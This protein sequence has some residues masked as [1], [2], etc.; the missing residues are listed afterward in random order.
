MGCSGNPALAT[1]T[2]VAIGL[3]IFLAA[4]GLVFLMV[5]VSRWLPRDVRRIMP[6][7]DAPATV[8]LSK[9]RCSCGRTAK[10]GKTQCG[11]CSR[12]ERYCAPI[13]G[14]PVGGS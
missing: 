7:V 3:A 11:L 2:G 1:L 4:I 5:E 9:T 13:G 6:P 12:G 14:Q 10:N 8:R